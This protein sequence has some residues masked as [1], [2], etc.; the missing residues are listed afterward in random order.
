MAIKVLTGIKIIPHGNRFASQNWPTGFAFGGWIYNL[1]CSIGFSKEPT[2]IT[3]KV[4]LGNLGEIGGADYSPSPS[5]FDI[6]RSDLQSVDSSGVESLYD[7]EVDGKV[8]ESFVLFSYEKDLGSKDKVLSLTFKDYSVVLDKVYVGL[9]NRQGNKKVHSP[10]VTGVFSVKCPDCQQTGSSFVHNGELTRRVDTASYVGANGKIRDNFGPV[11]SS[12]PAGGLSANIFQFWSGLSG[13]ANRTP[14]FF[15]SPSDRF[16]LNGGYLILGTEDLPQENCGALPEVRYSLPELIWSM[17][18]R[19]LECVGD[20]PQSYS[21]S[22]LYYKQNY[23]GSFREVLQNWSSDYAMDFYMSGKTVVGM[24]ISTP[25]DILGITGVLDPSTTTGNAFN[26]T[27]PS[28]ISSYKESFSLDNTYSQSVITF[29]VQPAK[30]YTES[31]LIQQHVGYL[32]LHPVEF[33]FNNDQLALKRNAYGIDYLDQAHGFNFDVC[34]PGVSTGVSINCPNGKSFSYFDNSSDKFDHRFSKWT[35]RTFGDL[36]SSIAIG[37]YSRELREIFIGGKI[38]QSLASLDPLRNGIYSA[39]N[40]NADTDKKDLD[41]H[42]KALGFHPLSRITD[43]Q[44]KTVVIEKFKS[45]EQG[46]S[47]D[48]ISFEVFLGYHYPQEKQDIAEWEKTCADSMYKYGLLNQGITNRQPYTVDDYFYNLSPSAGLSYGQKGLKRTTYSHDYEPDAKQYPS[49]ALAPFKDLV[50]YSGTYRFDRYTGSYISELDNLWG[51]R[52]DTFDKSIEFEDQNC[53]QYSAGNAVEILS[54]LDA[55]TRQT[56]NMSFFVPSFHDGLDDLFEDLRPIIESLSIGDSNSQ[57]GVDRLSFQYFNYQGIKTNACQ[58]LHALIIPI[59]CFPLNHTYAGHPNGLFSFTPHCDRIRNSEMLIKF[60]N[61]AIEEAKRLYREKLPSVCD[62]S[63]SK[64]LCRQGLKISGEFSVSGKDPHNICD[65]DGSVEIA[66]YYCNPNPT[67][68]YRVGFHPTVISGL[69]SR[70][71]DISIQRNPIF[72]TNSSFVPTDDN[73][74]YYL[75]DLNDPLS[76]ASYNG[77]SRFARIV[78]PIS[79]PFDISRR[80]TYDD[81]GGLFYGLMKT[82]VETETR[83]PKT[84]EIYGEPTTGWNPSAGIK[85]INNEISPDINPFLHGGNNEFLVYTSLISG[86]NLQAVVTVSG[87]HNVISGLNAHQSTGSSQSIDITIAGPPPTAISPF[88]NPSAGLT[89]FS[90]SISDVGMSTQLGFKSKP[91][92]L[93]KQETILNKITARLKK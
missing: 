40:Q 51:T 33:N 26:F 7:I 16:N 31:K 32:P 43:A 12:L 49:L 39:Y 28:A 56:W 68:H 88:L 21:N 53:Q 25:I 75:D 66:K 47:I 52:Q 50:V 93:A 82:T 6:T 69:N 54:D 17:K 15:S 9:T 72:A 35:N 74:D 63:I 23:V 45:V 91:P 3:A 27:E 78:Y 80:G 90:I 29:N 84:V 55:T 70:Y 73:G 60:Q 8:F 18:L 79:S 2:T 58:K 10:L 22:T 42:F 65:T 83:A 64:E 4:V 20:F 59:T 24:N 87:Y 11:A 37:K 67:G 85:V 14:A 71:L 86:N 13:L 61:D 44:L 1:D 92:T 89:N 38:I 62:L 81:K 46:N 77:A 57:L 41:A 19:G 76:L 30:T 48:Q 34:F 5:N 36:D